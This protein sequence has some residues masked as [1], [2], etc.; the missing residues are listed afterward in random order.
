MVK[1]EQ[2]CGGG[3]GKPNLASQ[4]EGNIK[5]KQQKT[6]QGREKACRSEVQL[7]CEEEEEEVR[8]ASTFF[9]LLHISDREEVDVV[10]EAR[11]TRIYMSQLTE[12]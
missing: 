4:E 1:Q 12:K 10:R 7:R 11:T 2:D 8:H 6:T 9:L 3:K 5:E